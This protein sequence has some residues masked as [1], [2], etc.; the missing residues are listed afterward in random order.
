MENLTHS[1]REANLVLLLIQESQIKSKT[2]ISWGLWKK[3]ECIFVLLILSEGFCVLSPCIVYSF[4]LNVCTEYTFKIYIL[5]HIKKTLLN[6]LLLLLFLKSPKAFS[7]SSSNQPVS[8]FVNSLLV[9]SASFLLILRVNV[10][11]AA[12]G[13]VL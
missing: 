10:L 6:T 2:V 5:L 7:T 8:V 4:F 3:K 13:G 9:N 1:S 12:T 11:E